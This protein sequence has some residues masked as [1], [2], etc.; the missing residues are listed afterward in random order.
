MMQERLELLLLSTQE[1]G[2]SKIGGEMSWGGDYFSIC[3][4]GGSLSIRKGRPDEIEK[5]DAIPAGV[6][7]LVTF[8]HD[9]ER[10]ETKV[11][12]FTRLWFL[13]SKY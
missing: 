4:D 5:C 13:S 1:G 7:H 12:F 10:K 6:P 3:N 2:V 11:S 9:S 8:S